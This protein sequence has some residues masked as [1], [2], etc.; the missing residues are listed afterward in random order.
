MERIMPIVVH[1]EPRRLDQHEFGVA[2]YGVMECVFRV[3][4]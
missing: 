2:A 3:H 1:A 4:R